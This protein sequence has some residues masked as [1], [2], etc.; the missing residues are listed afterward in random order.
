[1]SCQAAD[2]GSGGGQGFDLADPVHAASAQVGDGVAQ[3][4]LRGRAI[5]Q[6]GGG[7]R[8]DGAVGRH[9]GVLPGCGVGGRAIGLGQDQAVSIHQSLQFGR[10]VDFSAGDGCAG[11]SAG[12]CQ[13]VAVV[14]TADTRC[15]EVAQ[16]WGLAEGRVAVC[17]GFNR[18]QGVETA[19]RAVDE[20]LQGGQAVDLCAVVGARRNRR[21][22]CGEVAVGHTAQ[23]HAGQRCSRQGGVG[24]AAC[25]G[26]HD[27]GHGAG[28]CVD[29]GHAVHRGDH[30]CTQT[31][32]QQGQRI[33]A[34][35]RALRGQADVGA[36]G[37]V[38]RGGWVCHGQVVG[39]TVGLGQDAVVGIDQGLQFGQRVHLRSS[40]AGA[41][42]S[43]VE[44]C[45]VG[46]RH[47]LGTRNHVIVECG[48]DGG[49][50][51]IGI[52]RDHAKSGIGGGLRAH[53]KQHQSLQFV[54][55][56]DGAAIVG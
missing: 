38:L 18:R 45:Q 48:G 27:A 34:L 20:R 26:G 24:C 22:H 10:G 33:C 23:A 41:G 19:D 53:R 32:V 29:L 9:C 42:Q 2:R 3:Q 8:T 39:R 36:D 50:R 25:S 7:G 40:D 30:L 15:A 49:L 1:M 47:T 13:A 17:E 31:V 46:G 14:H 37:R 21:Q 28:Q 51:G 56:V 52:G 4:G 54:K 35:R 43:A 6:A 5:G 55:T 12:Y 16:A 11:Q 44:R